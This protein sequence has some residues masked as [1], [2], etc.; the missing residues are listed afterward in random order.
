M[1][2]GPVSRSLASHTAVGYSD[3]LWLQT[4]LG[5][6]SRSLATQGFVIHIQEDART[7]LAHV[8]YGKV[9]CLQSSVDSFEGPE[10]KYALLYGKAYETHLRHVH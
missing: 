1:A 10:G 6:L 4:V 8:R 5:P 2:V 7:A 3:F 9:V